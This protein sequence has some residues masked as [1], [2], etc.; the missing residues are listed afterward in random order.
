[1]EIG[2]HT[3]NEEGEEMEGIAISFS[4]YLKLWAENGIRGCYIYS[5]NIGSPKFIF[6]F[7]EDLQGP[8]DLGVKVY[9]GMFWPS[10]YD[11]LWFWVFDDLRGQAN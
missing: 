7:G 11:F 10:I 3:H 1:M 9:M 4:L 2:N 8:L 6:L 5:R